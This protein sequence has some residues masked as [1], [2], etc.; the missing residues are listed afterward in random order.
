MLIIKNGLFASLISVFFICPPASAS[1][2]NSSANEIE[3][4]KARQTTLSPEE[5]AY[6]SSQESTQVESIVFPKESICRN[7]KNIIIESDDEKLANKLLG[8]ITQQALN[9]C[10]GIEGVRLLS[11]KLQNELV[12]QGYITSLIDIPPQSLNSGELHLTLVWGKVGK[13]AF[14]P[15]SQSP[16][17]LWNSLP[18]NSGETLRLGDL[19]QGMSN[20]QRLPGSEVHMKLQPGEHHGETD[21]SLTRALDKKWQIGA[22]MDDS[23]SR[24]SGRYQGGAAL[25]LYDITRLNDTF[26]VSTGGDIEF[27]QQKD[28]NKNS[29]I[30]Y[31]IPFGYWALSLYGAYSEYRQLFKGSWTTAEYKS[32]NRYHSASLSRM[33]SHTREQKTSLVAQVFKGSSRYFLGGSELEVLRKQNP[34]WKLTLNHQHYFDQKVLDASLSFQR[35]L[36]WIN[37]KPTPEEQAGLFSKHSRVIQAN[38]QALMKFRLTGDKFSYAP[39]LNAQ[40]SPDKL[41]SDNKYNIGN[42]WTVRGFDGERTLSGQQGWYWRNDFIWDIPGPVQQIYIGVDIGKIIGDSGNY[43]GKIISGAVAGLRGE[44]FKTQYDFF[45]ATPIA[46]PNN[47]HSDALNLG[48]SLKWRI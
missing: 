42:R 9:K 21:I 28:G 41:S 39:Q 45:I 24:T 34:A 40:L 22:W 11:Q 30:F 26:Y 3:Q 12:V 18:L 5:K 46:K 35:R 32:K 23:G 27:N 44:K 13:I 8:K 25:Y 29:S 16:T 1:I 20:L 37:S 4:D 31:S 33:L 43:N 14:A 2:A 17:S 48:M 10:L 15:D 38:V 6:S 7:I 19:E 36:A 47:F